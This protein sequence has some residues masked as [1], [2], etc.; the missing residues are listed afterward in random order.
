MR[1]MI[2]FMLNKTIFRS[3]DV[4]GIY[5]DEI[6]EEAA[7]EIGK[8]FA[9]MTGATRVVV[10]RD[11]RIGSPDLRKGLI[12][13]LAE[14]G[15]DVDDIGL[16]TVDALYF[17]VGKYKY[18]G[19]IMVT[20]SHNPKEYAGMKF[21]GP[22]FTWIRGL[23]LKEFL[24]KNPEIAPAEKT[25]AVTEKDI[26]QEYIHHVLSFVDVEKIK[27]LKV[28]VDAGNGMMGKM[29][30]EFAKHIPCEIVPLFFE[31]DGNFPNHPSNPLE[32]ESQIAITKKVVETGAD[33]GAIFDGDSDRLF[34]VD[35][36]GK[37][38]TADITLILLAKHILKKY[39][40]KGIGYSLNCSKAVPEFITK[41]GGRPLRSKVGFVNVSDATKKNDGVLSGERSAH[42]AFRE[43]F[44]ADSGLIAFAIILQILSESN[45]KFSKLVGE[46]DIYKSTGEINLEIQNIKE[47]IE[48]IKEKYKDG[49]QDE[50]D[51]LTVEYPN[52]WFLAR[53][54]NT[55]PLLR[56][57][58]EADTEELLLEKK[59]ELI[60]FVKAIA[61]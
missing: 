55:E 14:Q 36:T 5:P 54:S 7:Y 53:P 40:G 33:I 22:N 61:R 51:G 43:N 19:G 13:G 45:E 12:R 2:H 11:M 44:Y 56:I 34:F 18:D 23:E 25:G 1:G 37:F 59:N 58:L 17:T 31:L 47:V 9:K 16:V 21:I 35:E 10:G 52:W 49:K 32:P 24:E 26:T 3:Y 30:P 42:Y 8:C 50:L 20:A 41:M 60:D 6:N 15:V 46:Y 38:I 48:K 39:P 57:N 28:V 27:P 4:R 29:M